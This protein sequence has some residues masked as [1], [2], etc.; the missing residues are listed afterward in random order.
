MKNTIPTYTIEQINDTNQQTVEVL[1]TGKNLIALKNNLNKPYRSSYYGLG[2]C[3]SGQAILSANL[4][5]YTIQK[6]CVIAMSPQVIKEWVSYSEDYETMAVFFT[7]DFLVNYFSN[8][9]YVDQFDFFDIH[10]K[11]VNA[12]EAEE[13]TPLVNS[14]KNIEALIK[15]QHV[16]KNE[17]LASHINI[18]LFEYLSLFNKGAFKQF[19]QQTRSQQITDEFKKLVN[20]HFRERQRVTFYAKILFV[21]PK[22]LSETIKQETGKTAGEWID[23]ILLL[24]AKVLLADPS[25]SIAQVANL[26]AF[27]D[28][29]TF[30]KYFKN[31]TGFSPMSYRQSL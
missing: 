24:E 10:V 20:K 6:N 26:L 5:K 4:E 17:L 7:Q 21:T 3:T 19:F 15:G 28:A 2:I 1:F 12:F 27:P 11:F 8:Q 29:S 16:Y 14:L 23:E 18:L 25:H 31:L 9:D 13:I 30:G 22:H